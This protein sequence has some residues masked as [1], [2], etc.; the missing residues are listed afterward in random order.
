MKPI[1]PVEINLKHYIG[2]VDDQ[3]VMMTFSSPFPLMLAQRKITTIEK[4]RHAVIAQPKLDGIR[5]RYDPRWKQLITR[6]NKQLECVGHI[7]QAI[8]EQG[9][10]HLDLDGELYCHGMEFDQ[11]NALIRSKST[12]E[13]HLKLEFHIFDWSKH[14]SMIERAH[15]LRSLNLQKPLY[16]VDTRM[17]LTQKGLQKYYDYCLNKG[18]EGIMLRNP[19]SNYAEGRT[20]NLRRLKPNPDSEA[21]L[22]SFTKGTG[23]YAKT[24]GSL[25]LELPN[26]IQFKCAGLN[27]ETRQRL[28]ESQPIGETITFEHYGFTS[29]GV[30]RSPRYKGI[31]SDLN[32]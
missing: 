28:H 22:I 18:Y 3:D 5:I 12:E 1:K 24:F 20:Q 6:G 23:K 32:C 26:G 13:K 19:M 17:I 16:F 15:F 9:L 10:D 14:K 31:R 25:L 4:E 11:I 7:L 2:T 21:K 8:K 27:D 30:P 29:N